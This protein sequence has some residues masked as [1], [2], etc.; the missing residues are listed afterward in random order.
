MAL[1]L[2]GRSVGD[3]TWSGY[4]RVWSDWEVLLGEL[5][6]AQMPEDLEASVLVFVGSAFSSGVSPSGLS[7]SLSALAFWFKFKGLRDFTKCFLV[8]QAVKGFRRGSVVRDRRRPLS[9]E[10]VRDLVGILGRVCVSEYEV[11]LFGLAFS[12]AFFGAFRIS[13]L[14]SRSRA[15]P[16]GLLL[17]DCR[18]SGGVLV[19]RIRRSKTD[20]EG[21]GLVVR[22]QRLPGSVVCPVGCFEAF[23]CLRPTG[24]LPLLVHRDLSCLSRFQFVQV[25]RKGLSVLGLVPGDFSS[26]SFRIG[27]ATEASRW[28][29]P[30]EVI[31][32][33]GRWES[34][35]FRSYVR[36][37]LL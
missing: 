34:D 33:I 27:A 11:C 7:R 9:F 20:Q 14:V 36:P 37:H 3:S 24:G 18:V 19:C 31:R 6:G 1:S 22:L 16:G 32:R 15:C 35:R 5:H 10:I 12:L 28:G 21:R 4:A 30:A 25:L 17:G 26:H 23:L 29:L 13:E 2:V 8:R